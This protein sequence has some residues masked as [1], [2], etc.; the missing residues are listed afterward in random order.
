MM[1]N[2]D[3]VACARL[4]QLYEIKASHARNTCENDSPVEVWKCLYTRKE[5]GEKKTIILETPEG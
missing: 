1:A 2:E 5:R 4:V 3:A